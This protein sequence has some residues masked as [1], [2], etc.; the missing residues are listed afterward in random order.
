[1]KPVIDVTIDEWHAVKKKLLGVYENTSSELRISN[2]KFSNWFIEQTLTHTN[3]DL[4]LDKPANI[5]SL[6]SI[7]SEIKVMRYL[8]ANMHKGFDFNSEYIPKCHKGRLQN[9]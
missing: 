2:G 6:D 7:F 5:N 1:M 9:E 8:V 4:Q 3:L